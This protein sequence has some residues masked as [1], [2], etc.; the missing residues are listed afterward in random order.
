M[1]QALCKRAHVKAGADGLPSNHLALRG[2][3]EVPDARVYSRY[4]K[5]AVNA[6]VCS[7]YSVCYIQHA[8]PIVL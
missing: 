3:P 8:Y 2:S 6:P 4:F 5:T 1:V 7:L